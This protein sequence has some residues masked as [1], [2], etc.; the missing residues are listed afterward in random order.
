MFLLR[1]CING[2]HCSLPFP[3]TSTP[4]PLHMLL[5]VT[6]SNNSEVKHLY[7]VTKNE[8]L[9]Q[10]ASLNKIQCILSFRNWIY[11]VNVFPK[12]LQ[13]QRIKKDFNYT[14]I[15]TILALKS[16]LG[17]VHKAACK[18]TPLSYCYSVVFKLTVSYIF[19]LG[20]NKL[21]KN[22]AF[23]YTKTNRATFKM[24]EALVSVI[25]ISVH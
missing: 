7:Y 15:V 21:F 14:H 19:A 16:K 8:A 22:T 12:Y 1:R 9:I 23:F 20:W 10:N 13:R 18:C 11:K 25:S 3:G 17:N 4:K 6:P 2:I 24:E 5:T